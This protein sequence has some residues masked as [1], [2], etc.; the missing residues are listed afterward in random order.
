MVVLGYWTIDIKQRLKML[1]K[2]LNNSQMHR[3]VIRGTTYMRA[4]PENS[5]R[6]GSGSIAASL[7]K[8]DMSEDDDIDW[9]GSTWASE[10]NKGSDKPSLNQI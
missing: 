10:Y 6:F 4:R 9:I 5:K 3:I 1:S 2:D 7:H 8:R